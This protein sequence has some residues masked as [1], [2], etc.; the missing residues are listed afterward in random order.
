LGV[1]FGLFPR[2][3]FNFL[4]LRII[5]DIYGCLLL[6][7]VVVMLMIVVMILILILLLI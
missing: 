3:F 1:F 7:I 2:L 5:F 6:I 4:I